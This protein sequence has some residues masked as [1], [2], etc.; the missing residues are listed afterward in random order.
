VLRYSP[1]GTGMERLQEQGS[2]A[3]DQGCKIAVNDP[4]RITGKKKS[5]LVALCNS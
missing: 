2:D 4:G 5:A 1:K 3:T